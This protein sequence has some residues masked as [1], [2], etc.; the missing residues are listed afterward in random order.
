MSILC[1]WSPVWPTDEES[2]AERIPL[3]LE[4]APRVVA[5]ERGAAALLG[6]E[7][8]P[9]TAELRALARV[10]DVFYRRLEAGLPESDREL[11]NRALIEV[12]RRLVPARY[13]ETGRFRHDPA[14]PR[15]AVPA[16]RRLPDAAGLRDRAPHRLPFLRAEVQR[17]VNHAANLIYEGRREAEWALSRIGYA[18]A[19]G[20]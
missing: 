7:L 9:L 15:S 11:A 20:D 16:L 6:V 14:L 19:A 1:L 13:A 12:S 17:E 10:L 5:E 18:D 8:E 4:E 3:I 2:V